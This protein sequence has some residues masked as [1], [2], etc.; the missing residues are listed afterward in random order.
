MERYAFSAVRS[1]FPGIL[2]NGRE[3]AMRSIVRI[4]CIAVAALT[5]ALPLAG[6][7]SGSNLPPL[8][9]SKTDDTNYRLGPGDKLHVQVLGAEDLTG[10]YAVGD[11]GTVSSPLIGDVKAAG[12]TRGQLEREMERKLAQGYLRNP[13]V[14]IT[15]LA[16][17]PFYIYGE[18]TKPGEYPYASGMRVTSAVA[19]AGGY[20]YR[21]NE[22]FVVVTR[23]GK[24]HK[25]TLNTPIQPDDVIRVPERY[26]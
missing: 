10:D 1:S 13:K 9:T 19:T 11:N 26:F 8:E 22:N 3:N 21:A 24:E 15:I 14:S 17:R 20:T 12:L 16:Y 5:I 23:D 4:A 2:V 7:S 18:V 6:C 25:A